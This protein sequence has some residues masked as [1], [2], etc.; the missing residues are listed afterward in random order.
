MIRRQRRAAGAALLAAGLLAG[1]MVAARGQRRPDAAATPPRS[2]QRN[3]IRGFEIPE[4]D[5]EG[6]LKMRIRGERAI[7]LPQDR[8]DIFNLVLE[9]YRDGKL[10]TRVE[11]PRCLYDRAAGTGVSEEKVRIE[12]NDMTITG[13][14]YEVDRNRERFVIR[15]NARVELFRVNERFDPEGGRVLGE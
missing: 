14:D 1:A 13:E 9:F 12:M 4:F 3:E 15:R 2:P 8:Y 6:R 10:D 5:D 7:L 11:S